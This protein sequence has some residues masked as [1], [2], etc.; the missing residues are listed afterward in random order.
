LLQRLFSFHVLPYYLHQ[1]DKVKGSA[2]FEV[3]KLRA[4]DL[5]EKLKMEL[6]GYLIPRLV[7]ELS[8]KRS[9][10]SIVNIDK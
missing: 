4:L 3:D 10:Q 1:L 6:P 5:V 9:K 7:E 8:G 2:H